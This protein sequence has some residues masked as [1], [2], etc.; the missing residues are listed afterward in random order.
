MAAEE[1]K[2]FVINVGAKTFREDVTF[3]CEAAKEYEINFNI[4]M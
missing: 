4:N 2:T 1:T 3:K